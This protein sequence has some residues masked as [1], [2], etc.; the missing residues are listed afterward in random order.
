MI[1]V[2][3]DRRGIVRGQEVQ[4]D[5]SIRASCG[6]CGRVADVVASVSDETCACKDCLRERLEAM[7]VGSYL[8]APSEGL[9][10]GKLT[11]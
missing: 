2:R 3:V 10:W 8:L 1:E 9:P 5:P 7:T 4:Q 11:S 6:L